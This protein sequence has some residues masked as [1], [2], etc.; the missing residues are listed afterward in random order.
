MSIVGIDLGTTNSLI[1]VFKNGKIEQIPNSFGELLTPSVVSFDEDG[2]IYIG[3]IAKERKITHPDA[4]VSSFKTFMGTTKKYNIYGKEYSPEELSALVIGQLI[5]DAEKYLGEK[6]EEAVISVPAYFNNKQRNATKNAGF[7][8]GIKVERLIN[9]PSAAAAYYYVNTAKK[10]TFL[11]FDFGGGTLDISIVDAFENVIEVVAIVGD[12]HLGGDDIDK[13]IAE[14]I[15]R[16]NE[17]S[18]DELTSAD[19]EKV[20]K[21]AESCKILLNT[22]SEV[23][24][25]TNIEDREIEGK[26]SKK[27]LIEISVDIFT[28]IKRLLNKILK[29]SGI[30]PSEI[31]NILLVGGSSNMK[32]IQEFI[33][34]ITNKNLLYDYKPDML[35]ALGAG[36][37]A[38]IKERKEELQ[39]IVMTDVCPF[40]LGINVINRANANATIFSPIIQRNTTLPISKV[41]RYVTAADNQTELRF[42]IYQ[43]ENYYCSDNLQIG[44]ITVSVP[45][46]PEGTEGADVRFTY[47]INGILEVEIKVVSTNEVKRLYIQSDD[48]SYSEEEMQNLIKDLKELKKDYTKDEKIIYLLELGKRLYEENMGELRGVIGRELNSFE[49]IVSTQDAFKIRKSYE[50]TLEFFKQIDE[51]RYGEIDFK[52]FIEEEEDEDGG[53]D[54]GDFTSRYTDE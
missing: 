47:D 1:S 22:E 14:E 44:E 8:A 51:S 21:T 32:I 36:M 34:Y 12:N 38:G 7:L 52:K 28:K 40:S 41:A 29:D 23:I 15:C 48:T 46:G 42:G 17:I 49:Y 10:Q 25:K 11:V 54:L 2:T 27:R 53:D 5:S 6:V 18:L 30:S 31:D 45:K 26:I 24:V 13:K 39:D 43:G 4:T 3:K 33:S 9:E 50:R 16:Q 19:R 20:L 37:V 35:V